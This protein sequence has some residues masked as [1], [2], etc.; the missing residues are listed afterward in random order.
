MVPVFPRGPVEYR[1]LLNGEVL[2]PD[3]T[4]QMRSR[5]K[6]HAGGSHCTHDSALDHNLVGRDIPADLRALVDN[7]RPATNVSLHLP[8]QMEVASRFDVAIDKKLLAD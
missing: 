6:H 8:L 4:F 7:E 5:L 3:I 1:T 2:A